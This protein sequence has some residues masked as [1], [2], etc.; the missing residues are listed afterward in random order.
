MARPKS[1]AAIR[2]Q[3]APNYDFTVIAS[4]PLAACLTEGQ[5]HHIAAVFRQKVICAQP[6]LAASTHHRRGVE[7]AG[8]SRSLRPMLSRSFE[9]VV[10]RGL[11]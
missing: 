8:K 1:G 11:Y 2:L 5:A 6:H 9:V 10:P 7:L 3:T 4:L